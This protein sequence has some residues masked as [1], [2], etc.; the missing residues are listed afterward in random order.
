M[1]S[2]QAPCQPPCMP[3]STVDFTIRP[4]RPGEAPILTELCIRS[5]AHWGYDA[6]FMAAAT[7]LLRINESEIGSGGVLV[8]LMA[9]VPCGM[10]SVVPLRRPHWCELSHLFVAPGR[11]GCGVGRALF[12]AAVAL[13]ATRGA[14]HISIL[15]DPNA[16][17][18]YEKL[19][20]R[21]CG[22]APS[23]VARNRMLPLFEFRVA[24]RSA[25]D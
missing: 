20:A 3:M 7:R 18:F 19:G 13:A 25:A 14:S 23:G 11:F 15:S 5:K 17:A 16:A 4:A 2:R 10:A 21:R 6:A 8:A 1:G 12:D 24:R 9:Q 22:A